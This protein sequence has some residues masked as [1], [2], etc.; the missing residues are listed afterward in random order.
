LVSEI[1]VVFTPLLEWV[2]LRT[3]TRDFV[4]LAWASHELIKRYCSTGEKGSWINNS[5][6][7]GKQLSDQADVATTVFQ[8]AEDLRQT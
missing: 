2:N 4:K 5:Q 1:W 7:L 8:P 3:G 6:F